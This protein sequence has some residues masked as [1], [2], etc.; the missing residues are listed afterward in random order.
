ME[1]KKLYFYVKYKIVD[2]LFAQTM[3]HLEYIF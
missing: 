3:I 1:I 2:E